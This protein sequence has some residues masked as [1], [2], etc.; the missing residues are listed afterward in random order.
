[1]VD[2]KPGGP[3]ARDGRIQQADE[4][5]EVNDVPI[6][7]LSH[8]EA[9]AV[10]KNTPPDVQLVLGRSREA[11]EYLSR[12]KVL[13]ARDMARARQQPEP[14]VKPLNVQP[15]ETSPF[16]LKDVEN[17]YARRRSPSPS[18]SPSSSSSPP[19]QPASEVV[20]IS[21]TL[22]SELSGGRKVESINLVKVCYIAICYCLF[23]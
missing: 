13:Q 19:P 21:P 8:Y 5:L 9:S 23:W 3:A 10:L 6:R 18:P 22:V 14:E 11:A 7:G 1:M 12:S 16:T 17:E 4:I 20:T 15:V 2:V